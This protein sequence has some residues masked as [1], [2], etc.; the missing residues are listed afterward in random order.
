[1]LEVA[2]AAMEN[3]MPGFRPR[4]AVEGHIAY[5]NWGEAK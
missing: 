4:L 1:V 3:A 2:S 5:N